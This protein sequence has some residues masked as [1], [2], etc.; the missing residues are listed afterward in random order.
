MKEA[1]QKK[2]QSSIDSSEKKLKNLTEALISE[3]IEKEEYL[4][5][6]N[7]INADINQYKS[8]L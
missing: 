3:L 4:I 6:K 5:T 1:V 2:L 8:K 7:Q